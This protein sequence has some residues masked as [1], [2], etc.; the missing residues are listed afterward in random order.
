MDR[1][2]TLP[3]YHGKIDTGSIKIAEEIDADYKRRQGNL[4]LKL[5]KSLSRNFTSER[6][7]EN[8]RRTT[9]A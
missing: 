3:Q 8:T 5:A 7:A 6:K 1:L 4:V 2:E 9:T